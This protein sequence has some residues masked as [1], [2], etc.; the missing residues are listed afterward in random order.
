MCY[1]A[2]C[3]FSHYLWKRLISCSFM[4]LFTVAPTRPGWR[5]GACQASKSFPNDRINP[6]IGNRR[7]SIFRQIPFEKNTDQHNHAKQICDLGVGQAGRGNFA[8]FSLGPSLKQMKHKHRKQTLDPRERGAIFCYLL[9]LSVSVCF[10]RQL[11][12]ITR[13]ENLP[14]IRPISIQTFPRNTQRPVGRQDIKMTVLSA[15]YD[16]LSATYD[17]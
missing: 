13:T 14:Y 17:V 5:I 2:I 8:A 3:V 4:I 7:C 10:N 9:F 12:S 1:F 11:H 16:A 6:R 15:E